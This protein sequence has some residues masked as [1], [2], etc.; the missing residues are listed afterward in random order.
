MVRGGPAGIEVELGSKF[1]NSGIELEPP[2]SSDKGTSKGNDL[3]SI[4]KDCQHYFLQASGGCFTVTQ[5]FLDVEFNDACRRKGKAKLEPLE[6][7]LFEEEWRQLREGL[8]FCVQ[9]FH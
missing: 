8:R 5:Y 3:S 2:F 9:C 1:G 7:Q 6:T 4:E